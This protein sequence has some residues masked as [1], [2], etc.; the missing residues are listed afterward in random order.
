MIEG[1]LG[2]WK[3]RCG[4]CVGNGQ[5][6]VK[7]G[8]GGNTKVLAVGMGWGGLMQCS[9]QV[10]WTGL[11]SGCVWCPAGRQQWSFA[12]GMLSWETVHLGDG[13]GDQ[14]LDC[15][16]TEQ[17]ELPSHGIFKLPFVHSWNSHSFEFIFLGIIEIN[18]W[19]LCNL[20]SPKVP[21]EEWYI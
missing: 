17:R 2:F 10:G 21:D 12:Q 16:W 13:N 4:C 7:V 15:W 9:L 11:S 20:F 6:R 19:G 18:P 3:A 8:G 5:E 1:R 14:K